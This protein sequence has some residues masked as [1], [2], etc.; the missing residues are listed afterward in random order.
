M[1]LGY[2]CYLYKS[3]MLFFM[4]NDCFMFLVSQL[5][6]L[7]DFVVTSL[8]LFSSICMLYLAVSTSCCISCTAVPVMPIFL[9]TSSWFCIFHRSN[10]ASHTDCISCH[11]LGIAWIGGLPHSTGFS[12]VLVDYLFAAVCIFNL[13]FLLFVASFIS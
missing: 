7:I 11:M 10:S 1:A 3:C 5:L 12:W 13:H 6:K 9:F 2:H 8:V 4:V